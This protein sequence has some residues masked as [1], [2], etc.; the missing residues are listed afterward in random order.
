MWCSWFTVDLRKRL[1]SLSCQQRFDYSRCKRYQTQRH[2]KPD[3]SLPAPI[4]LR[5]SVPYRSNKSRPAAEKAV[6]RRLS[7]YGS[8]QLR[9][10]QGSRTSLYSMPRAFLNRCSS[11]SCL[12][13]KNKWGFKQ[14]FAESLRDYTDPVE[15]GKQFL[16]FLLYN[17][18]ILF[19]HLD[20]SLLHS[21]VRTGGLIL[22]RFFEF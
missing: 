17:F 11:S 16:N 14:N 6:T 5:V 20:H 18:T 1:C 2:I 8:R 10:L 13:A 15:D 22:Q 19:V 4:V 3:K 12:S 7:L 9:S 21:A